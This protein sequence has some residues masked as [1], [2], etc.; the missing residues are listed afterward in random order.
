MA[1]YWYSY[2]GTTSAH[3]VL[4]ARY[5]YVSTAFPSS[6]L[7]N[8]TSNPCL[9]YATG[10]GTQTTSPATHPTPIAGTSPGQISANLQ[11]YVSFGTPSN[12]VPLTGKAYLYNKP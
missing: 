1:K 5:N 11:S 12:R 4:T 10:T 8:G 2:T 3:K 6:I 7:C 9:I